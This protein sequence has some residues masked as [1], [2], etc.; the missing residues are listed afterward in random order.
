MLSETEQICDRIGV[1]S[2]GDLL[3]DGPTGDLRDASGFE[4]VFE[5]ADPE[6]ATRHGFVV[7]GE[8]ELLYTV[9]VG[10]DPQELSTSLAGALADG[11]VIREL[12]PRERALEAALA[13][14]VAEK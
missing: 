3:F 9:F 8:G 7:A 11:L 12:R 1:I 2:K 4:V 10:P 14:L 13:D 6:I 5:P